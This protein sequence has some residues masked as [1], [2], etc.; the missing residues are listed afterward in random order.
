MSENSAIK[1]ATADRILGY[2]DKYDLYSNQFIPLITKADLLDR[3]KLQGMFDNLMTGGAIC[4]LNVDTEIKDKQLII[5]LI[6]MA[7]KMGVVYHAI[8][9]NIQECSKGHISVG[10]VDTCHCGAKIV[11]NYTR[12]VGFLTNTKNWHKVRREKDY[13]NRQFYSSIN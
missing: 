9:Y 12:T 11:N 4:H 8:N 2:N 7:V 6:N 13:P 10:K 3:V 1:L 5:D